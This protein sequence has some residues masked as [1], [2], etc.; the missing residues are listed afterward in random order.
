MYNNVEIFALIITSI[1]IFGGDWSWNRPN[2]QHKYFAFVKQISPCKKKKNGHYSFYILILWSLL[3]AWTTFLRIARWVRATH[4]PKEN[5]QT[6]SYHT[7][8]TV[9]HFQLYATIHN[10]HSDHLFLFVQ[11][12]KTKTENLF[13]RIMISKKLTHTHTHT[14]QQDRSKLG[15]RVVYKQ[16]VVYGAQP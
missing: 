11:K 3:P 5:D 9:F 4:T 7:A 16:R 2:A 15:S 13:R 1:I 14:A 6:H 12:H 10:D 8:L